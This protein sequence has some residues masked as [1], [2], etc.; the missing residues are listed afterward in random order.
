MIAET[1]DVYPIGRFFGNS[2]PPPPATHS[3]L[4][5]TVNSQQPKKSDQPEKPLLTLGGEEVGGAHAQTHA[6]AP[7]P[8]PTGSNLR[9]GC[10]SFNLHATQTVVYSKIFHVTAQLFK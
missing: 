10:A 7:T 8:L 5:N 1:P 2:T 3:T 4:Y 6:L 9:T